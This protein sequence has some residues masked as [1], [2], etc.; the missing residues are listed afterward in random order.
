MEKQ[1]K[2]EVNHNNEK[3]TF[4]KFSKSEILIGRS[5]RC[6]LRIIAEGVSRK[7]ARIVLIEDKFFIEDLGSSNGTFINDRKI[8]K[9]EFTTFFPVNIGGNISLC[10]LNQEDGPQAV[11]P[12]RDRANSPASTSGNS[13]A[14]N[15]NRSAEKRKRKTR[16]SYKSNNDKNQ[17]AQMAIGA[18][19]LLGI[20]IFFFMSKES[21]EVDN[22]NFGVQPSVEKV[23]I[24]LLPFKEGAVCQSP[25]LRCED[26]GLSQ[27]HQESLVYEKKVL[28]I[29][30]NLEFSKSKIKRQAKAVGPKDYALLI[31]LKTFLN[32]SLYKGFV[33]SDQVKRIEILIFERQE[34]EMSPVFNLNIAKKSGAPI[35][36]PAEALKNKD[37][38]YEEK[39][40]YQVLKK[41]A[42]F[43][44]LSTF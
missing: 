36:A 7:H 29:K 8:Q 41:L 9:E 6:D 19:L 10:L 12:F 39:G 28:Q 1:I 17:H 13:R 5:K 33:F 23:D 21:A 34:N 37:L 44:K 35:L 15:N 22:E 30:R 40:V 3:S 31:A 4:H 16:Q 27:N 2:I 43:F 38:I 26:L 11:S 32:E 42:P 24:V 25:I 14:E 18:L 20:G